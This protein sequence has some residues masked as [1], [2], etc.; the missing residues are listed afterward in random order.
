MIEIYA[1]GPALEAGPVFAATFDVEDT[2]QTFDDTLDQSCEN[3]PESTWAF[4]DYAVEL[5]EP[6]VAD[7]EPNWLMIQA[8][9]P[10]FDT[11]WGWQSASTGTASLQE[12]NG[13]IAEVATGGRAYALV[14][15]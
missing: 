13:D 2:N 8:V 12:F 14:R 4:Y 5:V 15:G 11:Y 9:T 10:G 6:F 7:G 1:D 3:R